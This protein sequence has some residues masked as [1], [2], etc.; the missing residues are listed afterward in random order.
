MNNFHC[1]QCGALV[2]HPDR[3]DYDYKPESG[4]CRSCFAVDITNQLEAQAQSYIDKC[5]AK[6]NYLA[7]LA[8]GRLEGNLT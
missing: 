5:K 2:Y 4:L 7:S 8:Q 3:G 1:K 6:N